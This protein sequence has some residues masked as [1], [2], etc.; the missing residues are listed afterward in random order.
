MDSVDDHT[1]GTTRLSMT[2]RERSFYRSEYSLLLVKNRSMSSYTAAHLLQLV[3][4][5]QPSL[6]TARRLSPS[7]GY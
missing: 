2:L 6:S 1:F 7:A 5:R 3:R 4:A